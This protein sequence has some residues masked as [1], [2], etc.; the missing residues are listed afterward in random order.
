MAPF[1]IR[2]AHHNFRF[3]FATKVWTFLH[4]KIFLIVRLSV[5]DKYLLL[6]IAEVFYGQWALCQ[7]KD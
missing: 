6:L 3:F 5:L 7:G 1:P 4:L 2:A